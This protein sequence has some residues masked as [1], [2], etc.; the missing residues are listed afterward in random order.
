MV[1]RTRWVLGVEGGGCGNTAGN[2]V[3]GVIDPVR[4]RGMKMSDECSGRGHR[5]IGSDMNPKRT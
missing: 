5:G 3:L 1:K 4:S 2:P